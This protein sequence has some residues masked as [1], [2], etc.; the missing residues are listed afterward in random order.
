MSGLATYFNNRTHSDIEVHVGQRRLFLHRLILCQASGFFKGLLESSL[1]ETASPVIPLES[2]DEYAVCTM[3]RFLYLA[4]R[5][6]TLKS[7]VN[8]LTLTELLD[9]WIIADKYDI[10]P[11]VSEIEENTPLGP[12]VLIVRRISDEYSFDPGDVA[13]AANMVHREAFISTLDGRTVGN[14]VQEKFTR[15]FRRDPLR[16][17]DTLRSNPNLAANVAIQLAQ[18]HT[19]RRHRRHRH[20]PSIS[21]IDD[22]HDSELES[23]LRLSW[24]AVSLDFAIGNE[25]CIAS[26][27]MAIAIA[28]RHTLPE[29]PIVKSEIFV[30]FAESV[31]GAR[32]RGEEDIS[33]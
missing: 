18:R 11:A 15:M 31:R 9:L 10:G 30:T 16:F 28:L 32:E 19:G 3:F 8:S 27:S 5:P 17:A 7:E 33:Q 14:F 25:L 13:K 29:R 22:E 21:T 24:L 2:Y 20:E 26:I 12:K 4:D 1:A 23:V 6:E